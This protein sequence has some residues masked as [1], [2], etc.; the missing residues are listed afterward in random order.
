MRKLHAVLV[1]SLRESDTAGDAQ[2]QALRALD[3]V[4]ITK[5]FDFVGLTESVTE[6]RDDLE[7]LRHHAPEH[8]PGSPATQV[9]PRGT[10]G[11]SEDEEDIMLD[12]P[13]R[14]TSRKDDQADR[15]QSSVQDA[16]RPARGLLVIDD[17]AQVT[18]P[19]LKA[20]HA[21]GQASITS[22]M[23]SLGHLTRTHDLCTVIFNSATTYQK[24]TAAEAVSIFS[25][26]L[27]R[28]SLGQS[29]AYFIDLH[30]LLHKLPLAVNDA[31]AVYGTQTGA[32]RIKVN[33]ASV[34]EILQDRHGNRV[35]RWAAFTTNGEGKLKAIS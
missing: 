18:N 31:K 24:S 3:H 33:L 12:E 4:R 29:F 35:G 9:K 13:V 1:S 11:D 8:S 22:F 34:L 17:I 6:L 15:V 25:S 14:E 23:C 7:G 28:P 26:C 27:S 20:N 2:A 19:L 10:V 5:A 32:T 30:L 21:Q 16:P